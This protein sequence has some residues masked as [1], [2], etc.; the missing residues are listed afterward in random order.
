MYEQWI[1]VIDRTFSRGFGML[2]LSLDKKSDNLHRTSCNRLNLDG[3]IR[4]TNH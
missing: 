3:G 4:L 2:C 1:S